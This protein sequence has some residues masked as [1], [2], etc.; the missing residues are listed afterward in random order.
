MALSFLLSLLVLHPIRKQDQLHS[1]FEKSIS[2][3]NRTELPPQTRIFRLLR[4]IFL[5]RDVMHS[6][7]GAVERYLFIR[8]SVRPS[9]RPSHV[10][11]L[12]KSLTLAQHKLI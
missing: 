12:S 3:I 11:I 8:P 6:A 9:V 5:P 4:V 2:V 1:H 10:G 7:D